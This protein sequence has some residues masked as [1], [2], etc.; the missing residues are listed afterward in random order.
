MKNPL[1]KQVVLFVL[2]AACAAFSASILFFD[3]V[4]LKDQVKE[5]STTEIVQEAFLFITAVLFFIQSRR[6][7]SLR[8]G[9]I[10]AAGFFGCMLFRELDALFD[11]IHLGAWV[12]FASMLAIYSLCWAAFTP[13]TTLNG[14]NAL[15]ANESFSILMFGLVTILVFS[16]VMG[17]HSIWQAA[18]AGDN[19]RLVKNL[20]EEGIELFGYSLCLLAAV[21]MSC[22]KVALA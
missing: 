11:M 4:I 6:Q 7:K 8:G 10:L 2:L 17:I 19:V 18:V 16:R 5:I 21:R 3:V 14:L 13:K 9:F 15:V 1:L 22:S 12:Y 20:V